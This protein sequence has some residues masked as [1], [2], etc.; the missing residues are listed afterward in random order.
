MRSQNILKENLSKR[1]KVTKPII[2]FR[3]IEISIE[4]AVEEEVAV[5]VVPPVQ[6]I[7]KAVLDSVHL[8]GSSLPVQI[9]PRL[10]NLLSQPNDIEK[11]KSSA[12]TSNIG[13]SSG[14]SATTNNNNNTSFN[15]YRINN[16]NNNSKP[17]STTSTT[18]MATISSTAPTHNTFKPPKAQLSS[19]L[20][21]GNNAD[22]EV[23]SLLTLH[24]SSF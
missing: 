20:N 22:I 3:K 12:N 24:S 21:S 4:V 13:W 6:P 5:V 23:Y 19:S 9:P 10:A 15:S 14:V 8:L 11:P 7:P 16:N 2:S 17:N 18:G 1:K